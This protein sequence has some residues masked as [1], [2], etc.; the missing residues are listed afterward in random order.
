MSVRVRATLSI[1]AEVDV[2]D[3][4]LQAAGLYSRHHTLARRDDVTDYLRDELARQQASGQNAGWVRYE[5]LPDECGFIR[6][7]NV[8]HPNQ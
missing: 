7:T 8:P 1:T 5:T 4:M 2:P 3:Y 6:P